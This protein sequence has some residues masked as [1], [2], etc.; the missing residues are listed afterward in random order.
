MLEPTY[1]QAL[2][3]AW[4]LA[5]HHKITWIVGLLSVFLGQLG[6]SN[7]V[8]QLVSE[9]FSNSSWWPA[10]WGIIIINTKEQLFWFLWTA[11]LV[12]ALAVF[13]LV[14]AVCAQGALLVMAVH[15]YRTHLVM[16]LSHAW[17]EGVKHFWG[18]LAINFLEKIFLSVI[19]ATVLFS[20]N[21]FPASTAG[22]LGQILLVAI[23]IFLALVVS[24]VAILAL[25]YTVIDRVPA[26]MAVGRGYALFKH[27][28][29]VSLELSAL[30][31][32]CN[33]IVVAVVSFA[34][35][36]ALV[37]SALVTVFAGVTGYVQLLAVAVTLYLFVVV[38]SLCLV[39]AA[40][41]TFTTAAWMFVFMKMHHEG[42]TS[43]IMHHA[44]HL[45]RRR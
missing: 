27:H 23:G 30:L 13:V 41:N 36:M 6:L 37:P 32:A 21:L 24:V 39:G 14:A 9:L 31:L 26:V 35:L 19:L 16:P 17:R 2:S 12:A 3:H 1:R 34:L 5:W 42:L 4:K 7:F 15:W 18:I 22:L 44:A 10:S 25:G 20:V 45:F 43:R 8:G 11:V 38:L 29:L 28:L 33:A 40:Y